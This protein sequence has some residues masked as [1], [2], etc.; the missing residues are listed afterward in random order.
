VLVVRARRAL[1]RPGPRRLGVALLG[2]ATALTAVSLVGAAGAAR[3]RWGTTRTVIV[4][5]RDLAP[6]DVVDAGAVEARELPEGLLVDAALADRPEGA[7]VRQPIVAGEPVVASRLA[8][9]GLTGTAALVAPGERAVTVPPGPA[10]AP[11]L[12]VGDLVDVLTVVPVGP[13]GAAEHVDD[14]HDD[15][16]SGG[17]EPGDGDDDYGDGDDHSGGGG[18][19][20]AFVLVDRAAV[21]DVTD[22][23]VT[24]AV[25]EADAP[26]VAWALASSTVVLALAGG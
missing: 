5:S 9:H 16:P 15:D 3:D 20:P 12:V 1:A 2:G 11:P 22:G 21:V 26:R 19:A 14:D 13:G 17:D 24:V 10:G 6:G 7:V 18:W 25:P 8:P 23:A 4:A